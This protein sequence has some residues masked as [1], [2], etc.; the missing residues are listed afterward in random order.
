MN[1]DPGGVAVL[2]VWDTDDPPGRVHAEVT[3]P[4]VPRT[5]EIITHP[6]L[7]R[8]YSHVRQ[9]HWR[10]DDDPGLIV[11]TGPV[12]FIGLDPARDYMRGRRPGP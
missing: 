12:V 2:L 3:L 1:P 8:K 11:S 4:A 9:V 7:P 6:S 5:G 10:L